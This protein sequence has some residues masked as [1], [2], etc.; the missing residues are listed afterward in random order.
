MNQCIRKLQ[1]RSDYKEINIQA[2]PKREDA[3][4]KANSGKSMEGAQLSSTFWA[5][6]MQ[7]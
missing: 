3:F 7:K 6:T 1:K 5:E 4:P 2:N